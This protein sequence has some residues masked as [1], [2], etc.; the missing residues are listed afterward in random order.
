V[1][2]IGTIITNWAKTTLTTA[3]TPGLRMIS[4]KEAA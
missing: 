1:I 4:A 3:T 2:D